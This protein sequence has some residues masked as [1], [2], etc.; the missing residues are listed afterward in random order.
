[1]CPAGF[2]VP[3]L[4]PLFSDLGSRRVEAKEVII[5]CPYFFTNVLVLSELGV[6]QFLRFRT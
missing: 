6:G 2:G 3:V 4:L 1:M 5:S